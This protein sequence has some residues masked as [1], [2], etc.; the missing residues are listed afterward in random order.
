MVENKGKET[1]TG[2]ANGTEKVKTIHFEV[3]FE[4]PEDMNNDDIFDS[5]ANKIFYEAAVITS[6]DIEVKT[7]SDVEMLKSKRFDEN[8]LKNLIYKTVIQILEPLEA[9]KRYKGNSHHL[10]QEICE[11]LASAMIIK[12]TAKLTD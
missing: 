4:Y 2:K 9:T 6:D 12:N 3:I 11:K 5:F 7:K 1:V 8:D 10:T